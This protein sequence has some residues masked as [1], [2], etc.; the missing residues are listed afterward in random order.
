MDPPKPHQCN[1]DESKSTDATTN[2]YYESSDQDILEPLAVVGLSLKFPQDATSPESLWNMLM[3]GRCAMREVPE[4]RWNLASFYHPDG[5]R[6]DCVSKR[7]TL[8]PSLL[9]DLTTLYI[10]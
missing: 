2:S 6:K 7:T 8:V 10:F 5:E 1:E 3:E 9:T 4:D